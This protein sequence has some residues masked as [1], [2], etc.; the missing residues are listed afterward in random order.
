MNDQF[1]QKLPELKPPAGK[2]LPDSI[3]SGMTAYLGNYQSRYQLI[4]VQKNPK[5]AGFLSVPTKDAASLLQNIHINRKLMTVNERENYISMLNK[6]LQGG[7]SYPTLTAILSIVAGIPTAGIG[8]IS[9]I[10]FTAGTT[11]VDSTRK[12]QDVQ[13]RVGD[14][15]WQVEE[16]GKVRDG[17]AWKVVHVGGYLLID[18]FRK[19]TLTQGWLIHEERSVI[20]I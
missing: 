3:I 10:L 9:G 11:A 20:S 1:I 17:N 18:P 15:L 19:Q 12:H 16:V 14:E 13:A 7:E 5:G 2:R 4:K 6:A 8:T